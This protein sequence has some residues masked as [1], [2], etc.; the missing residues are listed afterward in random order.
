MAALATQQRG[1]E[2]SGVGIRAFRDLLRSSLRDEFATLV[3]C[4][5]ADVDHP[6]GGF[7]DL[8]VMLD[9]DHAVALVDKA[10][11]DAEQLRHVVEMQA[12]RRFRQR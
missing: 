7:D 3:A 9:H 10:L 11:E 2:A 8:E 4:L 12:C 1:E 6:V 5:G